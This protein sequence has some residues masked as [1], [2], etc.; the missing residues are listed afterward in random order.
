MIDKKIII[1]FFAFFLSACSVQAV[2]V[3]SQG[4][5]EGWEESGYRNKNAHLE[6]VFVPYNSYYDGLRQV[7]AGVDFRENLPIDVNRIGH[8]PFKIEVRFRAFHAGYFLDPRF[9]LTMDG[10]IFYPNDVSL[11]HYSLAKGCASLDST[12]ASRIEVISTPKDNYQCLVV[13]YDFPT[14]P[15]EKLFGLI[16]EGNVAGSADVIKVNFSPVVSDVHY[17]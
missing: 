14:P 3:Q 2:L 15:P 11:G 12:E 7:V 17:N 4:Q 16:G 5:A 13:E 1:C 8:S 6:L 9:T 10:R